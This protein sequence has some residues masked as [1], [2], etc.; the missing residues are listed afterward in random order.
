MITALHTLHALCPIHYSKYSTSLLNFTKCTCNQSSCPAQT[1]QQTHWNLILPLFPGIKLAAWS[2]KS[3][4]LW[5][6][7]DSCL[8][9]VSDTYILILLSWSFHHWP[10]TCLDHRSV[11]RIKQNP[12]LFLAPINM[13]K[14][15]SGGPLLWWQLWHV[16]LPRSLGQHQHFVAESTPRLHSP[17]PASTGTGKTVEKPICHH[18]SSPLVLKQKSV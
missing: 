12:A 15:P 17:P 5:N 7:P 3:S 16:S 2:G 4:K 11:I 6:T 13:M 9:S 1:G 14:N 18:L 10:V 8:A